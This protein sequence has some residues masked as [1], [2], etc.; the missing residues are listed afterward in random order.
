LES[1]K[2]NDSI[3]Y[4][5]F[6]YRDP[7]RPEEIEQSDR[8]ASHSSDSDE[9]GGVQLGDAMDVDPST[10]GQ[11]SEQSVDHN[12]PQSSDHSAS[13]GVSTDLEH[14]SSNNMFDRHGQAQSNSS[15][16]SIPTVQIPE[17]SGSGGNSRRSA[18]TAAPIEIEAVV[19]C[20][21]DG[22]V[23]ILRHARPAI[24]AS[25]PALPARLA[26]NGVFAAPWGAV[27]ILPHPQEE[28]GNASAPDQMQ[29]VDARGDSATTLGGPS[30]D[31]FMNSIREVAVFA[32]ALTGI[33]GNIA[34]YGHGHPTGQAAPPGG[35]PVWDPQAQGNLPP[36][37]ENQAYEKWNDLHHR[38]YMPADR[39]EV[40]P[41][42]VRHQQYVSRQ[43]GIGGDFTGTDARGSAARAHLGPYIGEDGRGAGYFQPPHPPQQTGLQDGQFKEPDISDH[44]DN[45]EQGPSSGSSG[46]RYLW[47]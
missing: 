26:R 21:S 29:A 41:Q 19:S 5:R 43:M 12:V 33:N 14:D 39:H 38:P 35:F 31:N 22:L 25:Q 16:S 42:F 27:P 40:S 47:Y 9:D 11:S 36:P 32:W 45:Q 17:R 3:A 4:L 20:T 6:W 18:T 37:P 10:A 30:M 1:A 2:A 8:D 13:S 24:P 28:Y 15:S 34:S 46:D 44:S 7:R 23:V